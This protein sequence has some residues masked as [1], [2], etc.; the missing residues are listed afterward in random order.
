MQHRHTQLCTALQCTLTSR[1][2]GSSQFA[3]R[4]PLSW[5]PLKTRTCK[6]GETCTALVPHLDDCAGAHGPGKAGAKGRGELLM[7]SCSTR[8]VQ[9]IEKL[10]SICLA[11]RRS[12]R[13]GSASRVWAQAMLGP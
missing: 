9:A 12:M 6:A 13:G 4:V 1:L 7:L 10:I 2:L 11:G 3:G 5:L 8:R